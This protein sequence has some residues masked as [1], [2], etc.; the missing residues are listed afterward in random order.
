MKII[1]K[2]G[3]TANNMP[4]FNHRYWLY[5][6]L[7]RSSQPLVVKGDSTRP[8]VLLPPDI[9]VCL[10]ALVFLGGRELFFARRTP[11]GNTKTGANKYFRGGRQPKEAVPEF[12]HSGSLW[13]FPS[14]KRTFGP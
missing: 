1:L 11:Y 8:P 12:L 10:R 14:T 7:L 5:C 6:F 2:E 4:V 9:C 3:G 13:N